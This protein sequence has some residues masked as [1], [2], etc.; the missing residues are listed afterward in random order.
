MG[1]RAVEGLE[2]VMRQCAERGQLL[3]ESRQV[4]WSAPGG[5]VDARGYKQFKGPAVA[6]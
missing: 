6:G 5:R 1:A 3:H 4:P 2:A